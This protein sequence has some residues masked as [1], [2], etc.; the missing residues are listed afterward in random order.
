[1]TSA[2]TVG[3]PGLL[4]S[5]LPIDQLRREVRTLRSS[6]EKEFGFGA[7]VGKSPAVQQVKALLSRVA[8]SPASTVLLTGET[9]TVKDLAAKRCCSPSAS[10]R[11]WECSSASIRR[12]RRPD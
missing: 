6:Q 4:D 12:D 1:M 5:N 11:R 3:G 9:G 2:V 7:I 8:E 10:P